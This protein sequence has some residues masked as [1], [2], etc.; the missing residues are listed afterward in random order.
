MLQSPTF[1]Y[2]LINTLPGK[3]HEIPARFS[4]TFRVSN[5]DVQHSFAYPE[6]V[7]PSGT[8]MEAL[9]YGLN[10]ST[11]LNSLQEIDASI[12]RQMR[13]LTYHARI[14][15]GSVHVFGILDRESPYGSRAMLER[16]IR[17]LNNS[18]TTIWIHV[19]IWDPTPTDFIRGMHELSTLTNQR[20][21]IASLFPVNAVLGH[22]LGVRER[23]IDGIRHPKQSNMGEHDIRLP[24]ERPLFFDHNGI[25]AHDTLLVANHSLHGL[26]DLTRAIE[27]DANIG[28]HHLPYLHSKN[29]HIEADLAKNKHVVV[30]SNRHTYIEAYIGSQLHHP[31]LETF[32]IE[33]PAELLEVLVSPHFGHGV[34][35]Y[36]TV[37]AIDES[38]NDPFDFL[39]SSYLKQTK[40]RLDNNYMCC[41]LSPFE[42]ADHCMVT[43]IH[44][45]HNHM[46]FK[47][48]SA[49]A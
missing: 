2:L 41:F 32:C 35:P 30:V 5:A 37:V 23:F 36:K 11:Q 46:P 1:T 26:Q 14:T 28:A 44:D 19:G 6:P 49:Y 34:R 15:G 38:R 17:Q 43:N 18:E 40:Q 4:K 9:L 33:S 29:N 20:I 42:L 39:L 21:K 10:R 7:H 25:N 8:S 48:I 47:V 13:D 22:A 24:L 27:A 3:S 12:I 31:Y 16:L 45:I